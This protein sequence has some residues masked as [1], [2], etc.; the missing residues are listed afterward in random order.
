MLRAVSKAAYR[1]WSP[2]TVAPTLRE[3]I[4]VAQ[5]PPTGPV[6]V[7]IPIDVQETSVSPPTELDPHPI[8]V[9]VP[10]PAALDRLAAKLERARRPLLWL[11]GGARG[12]VDAVARL[13]DLGMGVVTSTQGRGILS[14]DHPMSLGAF[15]VHQPVEAFYRTCDA[16]LVAGSHLRGN[17]TLTYRLQL[18]RPLYQIDADARAEN[19]N[20]VVDDFVLGD[21]SLALASLARRLT[22]RLRCEPG[23]ADDLGSARA[24]AEAGV[25][26]GLG[27]YTTL[28]D[29]LEAARQD[30][31]WV[32]DVTISNSTWGNR[33][34]TLAG[35]RSG[36]HAVGGGIGQGLPM[37]IGA[38]LAMRDRKTICLL[39]D[40]GLQLS[41]G[42]LATAAETRANLVLLVMNSGG[43]GVIKNIQDARFGGRHYYVDLLTPD[44]GKSCAAVGI[45]HQRLSSLD[46]VEGA[47]K[48]ALATEGAGDDRVRHEQDWRLR[49]NLRRTAGAREK[50]RAGVNDNVVLH[51]DQVWSDRTAERKGR[52]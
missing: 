6:S 15:T 40:G 35:P 42:E 30:F 41:L 37:A 39:G 23:F 36:V 3:A 38:A 21:A 18:P 12:A 4:R 46:R 51:A 20:F 27:P 47:L 25:R 14:E 43:Y 2:E 44:F 19:R 7:E 5:T 34:P 52:P 48:D 11:G 29:V 28:I 32:R 33:L 10:S 17:E 24:D 9:S 49:D 26:A 50:R 8:P 31:L 1:A 22:G 13:V 45:S 16:M